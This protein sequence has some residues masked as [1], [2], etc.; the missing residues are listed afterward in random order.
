M[1]TVSLNEETN[2]AMK[3][4]EYSAM[5][6]DCIVAG[7]TKRAYRLLLQVDINVI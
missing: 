7:N 1:S 3:D 4:Y 5:I 6:Q 2:V